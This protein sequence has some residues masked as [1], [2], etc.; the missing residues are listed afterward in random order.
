MTR[1]LKKALKA[2]KNMDFLN[3][4]DARVIRILAEYLE[5][6]QR[7]KTERVEDT[8]V[9]FGSARTKPLQE[10]K[11]KLDELEKMAAGKNT[12]PEAELHHRI[13][14]ARN[15]LFISRYYQDAVELAARITT[16]SKELG[17]NKRFIICSGGGFGMMEAA[18]RGAA[19]AGGRS[20]GFNISIP[21]EQLPNHYITPEL[22]FEFH[23]FFMRKYWFIYMA[24]ALVIFPG[25]FGTFDELFEGLTLIQTKKLEKELPIVVYGTEYW[26]EVLNLKAMVKYG[27]IS[28]EDLKLL[29]FSD[30][31]DDAFN[32][33]K[34]ELTRI[35]L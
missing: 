33:L 9:F 26:N 21:H 10:A 7:L 31:V 2:Y 11:T 12:V 23:Y 30:S 15:E 32:F 18:N 24:K 28:S 3:S 8:V 25:G 13:D 22:N 35:C 6:L 4:R 17:G 20:I 1:S 19:E 29:H 5:P 14:K 16:W 27:T 34:K